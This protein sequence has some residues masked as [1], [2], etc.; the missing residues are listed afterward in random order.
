MGKERQSTSYE[1]QK[2]ELW[3]SIYPTQIKNLKWKIE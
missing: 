2:M 3:V 1:N